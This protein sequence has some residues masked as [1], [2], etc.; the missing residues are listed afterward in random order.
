MATDFEALTG[1]QKAGLFL[2]SIGPE[3]SGLLFERMDDE[4]IRDLSVAMSSLG[5]MSSDVVER[6]FKE[7]AD[8]LSG[9]GGLVGSY[10]TA[11]RLL[12]GALDS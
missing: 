11:E 8:Q 9:T 7:F 1:P 3:Q 2:L 4:E 10:S 5:S 6:L 12:A